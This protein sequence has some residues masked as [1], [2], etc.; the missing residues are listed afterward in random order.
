MVV[1]A[2]ARSFGAITA[3]G[4]GLGHVAPR[5]TDYRTGNRAGECISY[6]GTLGMSPEHLTTAR[7]KAVLF[8]SARAEKRATRRSSNADA[9]KR[10]NAADLAP[11]GDQNH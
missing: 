6:Q 2:D 1:R 8:K 10:I 11:I 3:L 4:A 7:D 5:M 9:P